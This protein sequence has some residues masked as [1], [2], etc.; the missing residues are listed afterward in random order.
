MCVDTLCAARV[1]HYVC[2]YQV[3]PAQ[4]TV[5]RQIKKFFTGK[6]D[7][8][9]TAYVAHYLFAGIMRA[10]PPPFPGPQRRQMTLG[11]RFCL[12]IP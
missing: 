1:C 2:A 12:P 9:V 7:A 6:L 5:A 3:T 10:T 8:A 4:I 11:L